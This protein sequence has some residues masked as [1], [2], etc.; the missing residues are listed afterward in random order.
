MTDFSGGRP[1]R[2][3]RGTVVALQWSPDGDRLLMLRLAPDNVAPVVP[4]VWGG[5]GPTEFP[6]SP[7]TRAFL[8]EYLPFWE[9]YSRGLTLWS[10]DGGGVRVP[11]RRY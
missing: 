5:S 11:R 2:V 9:Q 10:P 6:G 4:I 1:Q 3:A 7:P 8:S